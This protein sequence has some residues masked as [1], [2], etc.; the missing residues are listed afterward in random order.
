MRRRLADYDR[1]TAPLM[2]WFAERDK[3]AV[4]DGSGPADEVSAA[5]AKVIDA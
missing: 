3:L 4:V 2:A 5:L 1:Q